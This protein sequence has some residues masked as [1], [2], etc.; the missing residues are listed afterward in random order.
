MALSPEDFHAEHI[1]PRKHR[2]DDKH[3]QSRLGLHFL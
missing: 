3:G 2:G 1:I